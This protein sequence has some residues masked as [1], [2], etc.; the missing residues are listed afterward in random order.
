VIRNHE[1]R[2][3]ATGTTDVIIIG[4]GHSGLAA[5][6]CL[7]ERS[8]DHVVLERGDVANTWRN[9]RWD[10]LKLLTPNWQCQLPGFKY[11]GQDPNGF[12]G[13]TE[14]VGFM[15]SYARYARAPVQ[16]NT[17]VLSVKHVD[18]GYKVHT[19][20]GTWISRA[21]IIAS[22]AF[23]TPTIPGPAKD[24]PSDIAQLTP[25][26]YHRPDDVAEG[27]VLVVGASATGLQFANELLNA[28][29]QVTI[30]T[31]E[32]VR[33]PRSYRGKDILHWMDVTG[34]LDERYDEMD[35]LV[36][37]RHLPSSQL[38]GSHDHEIL[39]LNLLTGKGARVVGRVMG[40]RD[41]NA[42]F[43]GSLANVCSLADLK[44]NRLLGSIDEW[45]EEQGVVCAP[46][47][48][49]DNTRVDEQPTLLLSLEDGSIGTVIWATGFRPEYDWL[50]VDVL[51]RKGHLKHDGGVV[52]SP[53]LYVLGLPFMR[54][55]KSSFI[56]GA[57][58]DARDITEH[59]AGYLSSTA[60]LRCCA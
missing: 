36:R 16:C 24:L 49:F 34:L 48:R 52:E 20:R 11:S 32:H 13:M 44:M 12:M 6:Y 56:Y 26:T 2:F 42:Q 30:A 23:N 3:R 39:D 40:V 8:I 60:S 53:G 29:H 21:V 5:S 7:S 22:G 50:E 15:E 10:S 19:N 17:T 18:G 9:E 59:L 27:G 28:G 57:T 25:H 1:N 31:G 58:D 45:I 33:M 41:E 37:A 38:V 46:A 54:R 4:A 35:D 51:D 47:K 14:V 55:R 43:S